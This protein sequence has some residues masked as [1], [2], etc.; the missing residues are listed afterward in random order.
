MLSST[1]RSLGTQ[2]DKIDPSR[3]DS[4][5]KRFDIDGVILDKKKRLSE[6]HKRP[7]N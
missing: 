7:K 6:A 2:G 3:F 1:E 5:P 4:A